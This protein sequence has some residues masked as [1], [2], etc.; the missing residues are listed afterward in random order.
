MIVHAR[1]ITKGGANMRVNAETHAH[2]IRII[3]IVIAIG[4]TVAVA[5]CHNT[6]LITGSDM[7]P[8]LRR[9]VMAESLGPIPS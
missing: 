7:T 8:E 4:G 6:L 5:W 3:T 2:D 1:L 9:K